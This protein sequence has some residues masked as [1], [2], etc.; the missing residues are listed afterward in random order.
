VERLAPRRIAAFNDC[1]IRKLDGSAKLSEKKNWG[2]ASKGI[3]LQSFR[4]RRF[5]PGSQVD[6]LVLASFVKRGDEIHKYSKNAPARNYLMFHEPLLDWIVEQMNEQQNTGKWENILDQLR[7]ADYPT[8]VWIAMGAGEY[9]EWGEKNFL[10]VR[11]E[12]VVMIYDEQRFPMGPSKYDVEALF[13][14]REAPHG[15]IALHQTFV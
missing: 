1:S 13:A 10:Q 11:D 6:Q 7:L 14:D 5:C 4:I 2:S 9:T 3:S 8:S 12:V 15:I